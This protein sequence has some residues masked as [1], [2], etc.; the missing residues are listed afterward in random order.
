MTSGIWGAGSTDLTVQGGQGMH[1][2]VTNTSVH[3]TPLSIKSQFAGDEQSKIVPPGTSADYEFSNFGR[4]P[5]GWTFT[6]SVEVDT[7]S[8]AWKLFSTWIP[9]DPPN[10]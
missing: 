5:I 3:L 10:G 7:A 9:G 4:E 8:I 2:A 6:A 1:F